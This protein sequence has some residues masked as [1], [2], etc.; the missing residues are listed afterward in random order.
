[1]AKSA[2]CVLEVSVSKRDS[3][4]VLPFELRPHA[5]KVL[6]LAVSGPN[7]V[8]DVQLDVG[9]IDIPGKF[10]THNIRNIQLNELSFTKVLC[11]AVLHDET[12]V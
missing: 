3:Y 4:F 1:M 2:F 8:H 10:T 5:P 11:Y 12:A 9:Q 6:C 7:V